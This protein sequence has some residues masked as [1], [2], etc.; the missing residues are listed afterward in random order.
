MNW[1]FFTA[2][3]LR[4][5]SNFGKNTKHETHVQRDFATRKTDACWDTAVRAGYEFI[6]LCTFCHFWESHS[7]GE[8]ATR[9]TRA[10]FGMSHCCIARAA[11]G[12]YKPENFDGN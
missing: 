3:L 5:R 11:K 12:E 4:V 2:I 7:D 6:F 9:N 8:F 10:L 1:H